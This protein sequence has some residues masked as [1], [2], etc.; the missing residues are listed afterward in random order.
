MLSVIYKPIMLSVVMLS[1][2]MLT[3]VMLC[4]YAESRYAVCHYAECRGANVCVLQILC[5]CLRTSSSSIVVEHLTT[6]PKV[7]GSSQVS[8]SH[9]NKMVEKQFVRGTISS[10]WSILWCSA[11]G[12]SP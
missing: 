6:D 7:K 10:E 12:G 9:K 3:F 5:L 8:A 2:V 11:Q 1:A 4:H